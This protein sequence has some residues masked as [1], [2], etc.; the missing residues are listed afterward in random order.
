[1]ME[2]PG[3]TMNF[4]IDRD[5]ETRAAQPGTSFSTEAVERVAHHIHLW[6]ATRLFRDLTKN[7]E[8]GAPPTHEKVRVTVTVEVDGAEEPGVPLELEVLDGQLRIRAAGEEAS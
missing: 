1:M 8:D 4:E 6:L 3:A 5:E 7:G 2:T